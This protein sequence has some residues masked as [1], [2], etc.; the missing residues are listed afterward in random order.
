MCL[1][2]KNHLNCCYDLLMISPDMI[3]Q[4]SLWKVMIDYYCVI[5][6]VSRSDAIHLLE[7]AKLDDHGFM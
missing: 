1:N 3:L 7:N 2:F 4:L 6:G 5:Y